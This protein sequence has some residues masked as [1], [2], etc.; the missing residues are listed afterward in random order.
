MT[1]SAL[2]DVCNAGS[3]AST[4]QAL[5]TRCGA[6][7][8]QSQVGRSTCDVCP[9]GSSCAEGAVAP[10]ACSSGTVA[11][12]PERGVCADCPAGAYQR[13]RGATGCTIC[14]AGSYCSTAGLATA[15]PCPA[16]EKV[17]T[18][19]C[20]LPVLFFDNPPPH[21]TPHSLPW[22]TGTFGNGTGFNAVSQCTDAPPGFY[23]PEGS[24]L[25]VACPSWGF[26]AG[27]AYDNENEVPGSQPVGVQGGQQVMQQ[28][29]QQSVVQQ[30]VR[31]LASDPS[32]V[33]ETTFRKHIA[34]EYG[35]PLAAI[36]LTLTKQEQ[37]LMEWDDAEAEGRRQLVTHKRALRAANLRLTY[38]LLIDPAASNLSAS[39]LAT[40][41]QV[42]SAG[43]TNSLSTALNITV[44]HAELPAASSSTRVVFVTQDC[45]PGY[46][47]SNNRCV[48]CSPGTFDLGGRVTACT[49]CEGSF[50]PDSGATACRACNAGSFC[51]VGSAAALPCTAGRYSAATDLALPEQCT[52]TRP[53]FFSG[54]GSSSEIPC[55]RGMYVAEANASA[56][57]L[58][59]A[60]MA[61]PVQGSV[62]CSICP[63][64]TYSREGAA[65]CNNCLPRTSSHPGS[66]T[67]NVCDTGYYRLDAQTDSTPEACG[68]CPAKGGSCPMNTTLETIFVHP[69]HWRLSSWSKVIS[70]CEGSNATVRCTGGSR[71]S[72]ANSSVSGDGYC[73]ELYSGPECKLCRGGKGLY[74]DEGTCKEC[75]NFGSRV[76]LLLGVSLAVIVV[77][78]VG[79]AVFAHPAALRF[80]IV[81][82][83]RRTVAWL[84]SYA[85]S[86]GFRPKLKVHT[87]A[88][89]QYPCTASLVS[90]SQ[91]VV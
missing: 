32:D 82:G 56:C 62:G 54:I 27:R 76:A 53:G 55:P 34:S 69:G 30:T 66:S 6:G 86:I 39:G 85:R 50:Q 15:D 25:P 16:G 64:R 79:V 23:A 18:A 35:V 41:L 26:C 75:P 42:A 89:S 84:D 22:L 28:S 88:P 49:P 58:C 81:R 24:A 44:E 31:L 17:P 38:T 72:S 63:S 8:F 43:I 52:L 78:A 9:A 73:G 61:Q 48:L 77:V 46:W 10:V 7:R 11:S 2:P 83:S 29:V 12:Q 19:D 65:E 74:L 90:I 5:C 1:G 37:A 33:N 13:E 21:P 14:R 91:V 68:L 60:G 51:P 4:E 47:G 3:Y 20:W 80:T 40:S 70:S 87:P 45:P 59:G 57:S 71:A 67:C 36:R